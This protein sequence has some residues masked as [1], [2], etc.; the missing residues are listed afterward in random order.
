MDKSIMPECYAD[1][2]LIETLVPTK[3]GYNHQAGCFTVE[4]EMKLGKF[5]DRFALGII[6]NDK[7]QIKYLREFE[8]IDRVERSLILWRHQNKG[9]HHYIIQICPAL[10]QW[11]LDVCKEER[12]NAGDFGIESDL[13]A[14]KRYTKSN[15][16]GNDKYLMALFKE[17]SS[18]NKNR[19][20][21][22]LKS[23]ITLLK[24]KHYQVE[25]N[26]LKNG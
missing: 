9:K 14:L 10:E 11:I 12:I 6:D 13:S 1:T 2:L 25:I 17:I 19:N 26:Q 22:K 16:S 20:V 18:K 3:I 15:N 4:R 23:W 8:V 21:E 7:V 5:K 24:E